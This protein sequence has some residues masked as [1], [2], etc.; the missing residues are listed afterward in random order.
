MEDYLYKKYNIA[1]PRYTSYPTVPFWDDDFN[2]NVS[3]TQLVGEAFKAMDKSEG[4]SL[5]LHLPFCE[6]LCTYCGCNKRITT[7]HSVEEVYMD[8]L[9]KEWD[10]YLDAFGGKPVLKEIHL[11]G[12]TPTFFSP[13]NLRKLITTLS[14]TASVA[15]NSEFGFEGHPN[16]TTREHLEVLFELGFRRVSFGVQDFD[17]VVQKAINR[18]QPFESVDKAVRN[19][20][21]TGYEWINFDLIYGLPFQNQSSILQTMEYMK[22][23]RPERIAFYS[24]AHVP[25]KA[26]GQRGYSDDDLP[27]D[28]FKRGLYELGREKLLE[29]GY[30]EIGMDHFALPEDELFKAYEKGVLNRNFMGYTTTNTDMLIGL[31]VSSISDISS[32]YGQNEKIINDYYA[33]LDKDEL[34]IIK[35]V[36][37]SHSNSVIRSTIKHVLCNG[38]SDISAEMQA[39]MTEKQWAT[40]RDIE[41]DGLISLTEDHIQIKEEGKPYIRTICAVFDPTIDISINQQGLFSTSI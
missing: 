29:M 18:I 5:Y 11:G 32:A 17:P 25:W 30:M 8:Y 27:S 23:L 35:G 6:K 41:H 31:G 3:W 26:K 22:V 39:I 1:V 24:Y 40:L 33:R 4:I 2:N 36:E 28:T 19:A 10:M 37:V 14:D 34:P 13:N 20:R 12:G 38:V 15:E 16:N 9:F 7:N 21:E